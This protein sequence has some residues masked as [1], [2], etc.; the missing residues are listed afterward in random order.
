LRI[1]GLVFIASF[2]STASGL[3]LVSL[4]RYRSMMVA[5]ASA[6]VLNVIL[7]LL[8][9]PA[10]GARG[11]AL[12]D[13]ITE[14]AVAIVL[15]VYLSRAVAP[16]RIRS[17]AGRPVVLAALLSTTVLLIPAG[18]VPRVIGATFI[19]FGVLLLLRAIPAEVITAVRGV[20]TL[21]TQP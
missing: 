8:L 12:S 21:H 18:S 11:G 10:L 6:L 19:Y 5:S 3:A 15:T 2:I 13:V 16:H 14:A 20:R 1:Q 17:S 4:R 7:C 9:I